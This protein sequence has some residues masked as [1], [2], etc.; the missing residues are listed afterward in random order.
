ML[1]QEWHIPR[2]LNI[3]LYQNGLILG[4]ILGEEN[5]NIIKVANKI[6]SETKKYLEF[7]KTFDLKQIIKSLTRVTTSTSTLI[8]HTQTNTNEKITQC[9]LIDIGLSTD[10]II[11]C[12]RKIK[13]E[14][15][16]GHQQISFISFKNYSQDEYEKALGKLHSQ[17]MIDTII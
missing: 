1:S 17:T 15:V 4:L 16:G 8:D 6:S 3:N 13:K 7:F 9:G 11:F 12:T 10:Q 14:K 2:D 5:E